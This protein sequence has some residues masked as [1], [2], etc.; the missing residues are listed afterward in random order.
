MLE[1]LKKVGCPDPV[2]P[3]PTEQEKQ[4]DTAEF[5]PP[6][7]KKKTEKNGSSKPVQDKNTGKN[8]SSKP[9]QDKNTGKSGSSKPVQD[10]KQPS[11]KENLKPLA[12]PQAKETKYSAGS[13]QEEMRNYVKEQVEAGQS[14][15]DA[16][17]SWRA[18][19]RRAELLAGLSESE[20]KR[21]RF[22]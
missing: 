22:K 2:V 11:K 19:S 7:K 6:Q 3:C 1:V 18:S 5:P 15:R 17:A 13:F 21:R 20:L 4:D 14:H 12:L 10:K 9:V 8:G 16:Q